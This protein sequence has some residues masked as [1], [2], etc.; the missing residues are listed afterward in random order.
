MSGRILMDAEKA[1]TDD[2]QPA[3]AIW[4]RIGAWSNS[5]VR[6]VLNELYVAGKADRISRDLPGQNKVHLYRR[7]RS[8]AGSDGTRPAAVAGAGHMGAIVPL[9]GALRA[10]AES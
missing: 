10:A 7:A 3:R 4:R 2:F 5:S 9:T 8:P 1:L 6:Q